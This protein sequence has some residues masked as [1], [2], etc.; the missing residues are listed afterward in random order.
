MK[1]TG[2]FVELG[3]AKRVLSHPAHPYSQA[4]FAAVPQVPA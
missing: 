3:P 2:R 4:L 1:K